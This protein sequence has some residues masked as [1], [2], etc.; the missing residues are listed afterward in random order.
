M[1]NSSFKNTPFFILLFITLLLGNNANA[2]TIS[3]TSILTSAI[4]LV[5]VD[6]TTKTINVYYHFELHSS[7]LNKNQRY[8][9]TWKTQANYTGK[10]GYN[11]N[12]YH[13]NTA[14]NLRVGGR[15]ISM[16]TISGAASTT[17]SNSSSGTFDNTLGEASPTYLI[18]DLIDNAPTE[19]ACELIAE[20]FIEIG[21]IDPQ[22]DDIH[23]AGTIEYMLNYWEEHCEFAD[24]ETDLGGIG[25]SASNQKVTQDLVDP[26]PFQSQVQVNL[27]QE[28]GPSVT[29]V[30]DMSG[31]V[32]LTQ[33]STAGNILQLNLNHLP[34]G[35]YILRVDDGKTH[36]QKMI[37]KN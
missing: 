6:R 21:V 26:N 15:G 16:N 8:R 30:M 33:K 28:M 32:W 27:D 11:V 14:S 17:V 5:T 35:S 37:I 9:V 1:K 34:K 13:S 4:D 25:R 3:N 7:S 10:A 24:D 23:G 19:E 36:K 22:I 2:Q 12:F 29:R 18:I 31:K 20:H